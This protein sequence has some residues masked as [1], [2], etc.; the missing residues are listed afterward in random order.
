M[1]IEAAV[2]ACVCYY[3]P[4]FKSASSNSMSAKSGFCR[5]GSY[6]RRDER[7]VAAALTCLEKRCRRPSR[8]RLMRSGSPACLHT[9]GGRRRLGELV[10]AIEATAWRP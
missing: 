5:G 8:Y 4:K 3:V 1:R 10:L 7:M 6:T 9:A 2:T